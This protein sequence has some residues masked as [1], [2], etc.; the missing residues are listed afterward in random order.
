MRESQNV[1]RFVPCCKECQAM[2]RVCREL[3]ARSNTLHTVHWLCS[4]DEQGVDPCSPI[5]SEARCPSVQSEMCASGTDWQA[6]STECA[7]LALQ[8]AALR[9]PLPNA[10]RA[11]IIARNGPAG[12]RKRPSAHRGTPA[13]CSAIVTALRPPTGPGARLCRSIL[14]H[15][16]TRSGPALP[17]GARGSPGAVRPARRR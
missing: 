15:G 4:C 14:R 2:G 7:I 11:P 8:L 13:P 9:G 6:L 17:A 5:A 3:T 1:R 16:Q 10:R 12:A